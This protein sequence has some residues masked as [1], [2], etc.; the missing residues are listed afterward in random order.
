MKNNKKIRVF[1]LAVLT[2]MLM[3]LATSCEPTSDTSISN[4]PESIYK[5]IDVEFKD[6]TFT[7]DGNVKSISCDESKLPAGVKVTYTNNGKTQVGSYVVTAHFTS[8]DNSILYKDKTARLIIKAPE[9]QSL[10]WY[11]MIAFNGATFNYDGKSHSIFID[12]DDSSQLWKTF[13]PEGFA[14]RYEGNNQVQ[15]GKHIVKAIIYNEKTN[16]PHYQLS[17][18]MTINKINYDIEEIKSKLVFNADDVSFGDNGEKYYNFGYVAGRVNRLEIIDG[19]SKDLTPF[20]QNNERESDGVQVVT[21]YFTNSNPNYNDP[22]PIT[23]NMRVRISEGVRISFYHNQTEVLESISF[24]KGKNCPWGKSELIKMVQSKDIAKGYTV[25]LSQEQEW[26]LIQVTIDQKINFT[27]EPNRYYV[28]YNLSNFSENNNSLSYLYGEEISLQNPVVNE[29][30]Y[31]EGWYLRPDYSI[32]SKIESLGSVPS[33]I[34]VYGRVIR[35]NTASMTLNSKKYVYDGQPHTLQVGLVP[36][37]VNVTYKY[38]KLEKTSDDPTDYSVISTPLVGAYPTEIGNYKVTASFT[39][40]KGTKYCSDLVAFLSIVKNTYLDEMSFPDSSFTYNDSVKDIPYV[41]N[42]PDGVAVSYKYY[43]YDKDD[44]LIIY[45]PDFDDA[46]VDSTHIKAV[47]EKPGNYLVEATFNTPSTF[48][49]ID[50]MYANLFIDKIRLTVDSSRVF[51]NQSEGFANGK[52]V[53]M[54]FYGEYLPTDPVLGR[55]VELDHLSNDKRSEVGSQ[56]VTAYLKATHPEYYYDPEPITATLTVTLSSSYHVRFFYVK[57]LAGTTELISDSYVASNSPISYPYIDMKSDMVKGGLK[58]VTGNDAYFT[59]EYFN[60]FIQRWAPCDEY[61]HIIPGASNLENITADTDF[62]LTYIPRAYTIDFEVENGMKINPIKYYAYHPYYSQFYIN[63]NQSSTSEII[64]NGF[65]LNAASVLSATPNNNY[66]FLGWQEKG[67]YKLFDGKYI[68]YVGTCPGSK[69]DGDIGWSTK[70][71]INGRPYTFDYGDHTLVADIRGKKTEIQ[72]YY[73]DKDNGNEVHLNTTIGEKGYFKNTTVRVG[74]PYG[75]DYSSMLVDDGIETIEK[76]LQ[77]DDFRYSQVSGNLAYNDQLLTFDG[78]Y[79]IY[80]NKIDRKTVVDSSFVGTHKIYLRWKVKEVTVTFIPGLGLSSETMYW[81]YEDTITSKDGNEPGSVD[82]L[83]NPSVDGYEF[84]GWLYY[85]NTPENQWEVKIYDT[86]TSDTN[87]ITRN[88]STKKSIKDIFTGHSDSVNVYGCWKMKSI[89]VSFEKENTDDPDFNV[90]NGSSIIYV[91][92]SDSSTTG[93]AKQTYDTHYSKALPELIPITTDLTGSVE[94]TENGFG[95]Y[96]FQGWYYGDTK[97]EKGTIIDF[98]DANDQ[99]ILKPR[100]ARKDYTITYILNNGAVNDV[101]TQTLS[102]DSTFVLPDFENPVGCQKYTIKLYWDDNSSTENRGNPIEEFIFV[103]QGQEGYDD[104]KNLVGKSLKSI[105][106]TT[107]I[108]TKL[109]KY[110]GIIAVLSWIGDE[111]IIDF[112]D[113]GGV[114]CQKENGDIISRRKSLFTNRYNQVTGS[115]GDTPLEIPYKKGY[116]FLGW[117]Y[118]DKRIEDTSIIQSND[119][120]LPTEIIEGVTYKKIVLRASWEALEF[121]ITLVPDN[122]TNSVTV[123]VRYNDRF[124]L[125]INYVKTGYNLNGWVVEGDTEGKILKDAFEYN[126]T[127]DITIKANWVAKKY[128]AEFMDINGAFKKFINVSYGEKFDSI[129]RDGTSYLDFFTGDGGLDS[130]KAYAVDENVPEFI[131]STGAIVNL[132]TYVCTDDLTDGSTIRLTAYGRPKTFSIIYNSNRSGDIDNVTTVDPESSAKDEAVVMSV[133]YGEPFTPLSAPKRDGFIFVSWKYYLKD[134]QTGAISE[135]S[136]NRPIDFNKFNQISDVVALA[137]WKAIAYKVTFNFF[138]SADNP[139]YV[140]QAIVGD[141]ATPTTNVYYG[142]VI[143]APDGTTQN[144]PKNYK[145]LYWQNSAD[146]SFKLRSDQTFVFD[147]TENLTFNAVYQELYDEEL[148]LLTYTLKVIKYDKSVIKT[149]TSVY[150]GKQIGGLEPYGKYTLQGHGNLIIEADS[151][152]Y[153]TSPF[154]FFDDKGNTRNE[155]TIVAVPTITDFTINKLSDI[156]S[157]TY[158]SGENINIIQAGDLQFQSGAGITPAEALSEKMFT[159]SS[160]NA[161]VAI[162]SDDGVITC[163]GTGQATITVSISGIKQTFKITVA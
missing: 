95:K 33:D 31:F 82:L 84:V 100:F 135:I 70:N 64:Y 61:G 123:K 160:D 42:V 157:K 158:S 17:A 48:E 116:S 98:S 62:V 49:K 120:S 88:E 155:I 147:K 59:E 69:R 54:Q 87:L 102:Y 5:D 75:F 13:I 122:G 34:N 126:Y 145:F 55:L 109:K 81:N 92:G 119:S 45:C 10:D 22:S 89:K 43:T 106:T 144:L 40:N 115:D 111:V 136:E 76:L 152:G 129:F 127:K 140:Y 6:Q 104:S 1:S 66:E 28:T 161:E 32:S 94:F 4:L 15:A 44:N 14:L 50:N 79:D 149:D 85:T 2:S 3:P 121:N 113:E 139:V 138:N 125:P 110:S 9:D 156:T 30:Y 63:E 20:Y 105:D 159:F 114:S 103:P 12:G 146:S 35:N 51:P 19:L 29:G 11:S 148:H 26:K 91:Y 38:E 41:R 142:Q 151:G 18:C 132:T 71:S 117:Y 27:F 36:E 108:S 137:Q 52:E 90:K 133:I 56:E 118:G 8:S 21:I 162:V 143:S 96:I 68:D 163:V 154:T 99:I 73:I 80:G 77:Y 112:Q 46:V 72:F 97:I 16:T 39:D 67:N 101:K 128:R 83:A 58:F 25:S 37:G 130:T 57:D 150:V 107:E 86:F 65:E 153:I 78:F 74:Y 7:Y 23:V 60:S 24:E 93:L 124:A 134:S 141:S 131:L 53:S 47:P